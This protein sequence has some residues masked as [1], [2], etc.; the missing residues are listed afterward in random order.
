MEAVPLKY[1]AL[2]RIHQYGEEA[3]ALQRA[4]VDDD[5]SADDRH[6]ASMDERLEET[7]KTMRG[8]VEKQRDDLEKVCTSFSLL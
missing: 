2:L 6:A 3:R 7:L 8:Q 4:Q 5:Y 1:E